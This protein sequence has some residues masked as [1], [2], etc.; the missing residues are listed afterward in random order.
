MPGA[1]AA[2]IFV[3]GLPGVPA[4]IAGSR[5]FDSLKSLKRR[6]NTPESTSGKNRL[7]KAALL[8]KFGDRCI[9]QHCNTDHISSKNYQYQ[10]GCCVHFDRLQTIS[11]IHSYPNPGLFN[12]FS[13]QPSWS[14]RFSATRPYIPH[15]HA[16][17]SGLSSAHPLAATTFLFTPRGPPYELVGN[18][19]PDW[20]KQS[21]QL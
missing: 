7:V 10:I 20:W 13:A 9:S 18:R 5:V 17:P 21:R 12:F 11:S 8:W 14:L 3:G 16:R 4:C 1:P 2:N 19:H 15:S 6:L